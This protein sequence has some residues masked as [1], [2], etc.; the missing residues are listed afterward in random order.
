LGLSQSLLS[1]LSQNAMHRSLEIPTA[2]PPYPGLFP[3]VI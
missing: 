3:T 2:S 1:T